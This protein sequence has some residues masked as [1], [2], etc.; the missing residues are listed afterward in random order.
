MKLWLDPQYLES[1]LCKVEWATVIDIL[2]DRS[3]AW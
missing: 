1:Q 3:K 2:C